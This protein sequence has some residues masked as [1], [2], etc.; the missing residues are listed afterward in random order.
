MIVRLLWGK[1]LKPNG[2]VEQLK[3]IPPLALTD[4][5]LIPVSSG[6]DNYRI[7]AYLANIYDFQKV[8]I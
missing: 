8:A 5:Y 1:G 3:G 4:L 7:I 2:R 6:P